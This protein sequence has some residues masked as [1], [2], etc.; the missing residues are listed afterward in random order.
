MIAKTKNAAI[1][2]LLLTF[3]TRYQRL[4]PSLKKKD[5]A[6]YFEI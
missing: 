5:F 6:F 1:V 3:V 2:V 4:S